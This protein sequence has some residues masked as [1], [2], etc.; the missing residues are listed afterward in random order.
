M[1]A[2]I[3][4]LCILLSVCCLA[5]CEP[6][7]NP[8]P[9]EVS[10]YMPLYLQ[11]EGNDTVRFT[12]PQPTVNGGKIYLKG[13]ILYQIEQYKGIHIINVTDPEIAEKIGFYEIFGCNQITMEGKYMYVNSARD[14]LVID[15]SDLSLPRLVN[16]YPDYFE[17]FSFP[18]PPASGYFECVDPSKGI[19]TGWKKVTLKSPE[20]RYF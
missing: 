19:V 3:N 15:V 2:F 12:E 8:P 20:C 7:G 13:N 4:C 9:L 5:G 17:A 1:K 16:Y 11:K 18:P 14:F 6:D 10:G